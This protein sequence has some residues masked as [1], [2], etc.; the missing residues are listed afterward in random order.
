[1][2]DCQGQLLQR[3]RRGIATEQEKLALDAHLTYCESCSLIS[4]IAEDFEEQGAA[5]TGDLEFVAR[6]AD[7]AVGRTVPGGAG[8]GLVNFDSGELGA[9]TQ[10][11][12][13]RGRFARLALAALVLSGAA[14]AA[15]TANRLMD[16]SDPLPSP[17]PAESGS[18]QITSGARPSVPIERSVAAPEDQASAHGSRDNP[19]TELPSLKEENP[20]AKEA[21]GE[22]KIERSTQ[23]NPSSVM[24]TPS[25]ATLYKR[26]NEA[27]RAGDTAAAVRA[28]RRLQNTHG[29]AAEA[30]LSRVSLGGIYLQSG[31]PDGALAQ[32]ESYLSSGDPRLAAEALFGK[33]Q[34]L[35]AL[36]RRAEETQT[37]KQLLRRY[38]NS[39][40]S[41]LARDR[42]Q[43]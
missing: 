10:M 36:G 22:S 4:D 11:R 26:A 37:W 33:G 15:I 17:A 27:R 39:A 29:G 31:N 32:F 13:H 9:R 34:A 2:S 6:I 42:V 40:Y 24:R 20:S 12:V 14:A 16:R 5:Q 41:S 18:D 35:R 8:M 30:R 28:Y 7:R 38:P 21:D 23:G 3:V 19:E 43:E 1:M 25:A